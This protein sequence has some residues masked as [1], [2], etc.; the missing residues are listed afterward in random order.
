MEII[1][2]KVICQFYVVVVVKS[3]EF[4][5]NRNAKE[6]EKCLSQF[7]INYIYLA[8]LQICLRVGRTVLLKVRGLRKICLN[9]KDD[10]P[11]FGT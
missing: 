3:L 10:R 5:E 6:K 2:K 8:Y 11:L 1:I 4:C 9:F 7:L